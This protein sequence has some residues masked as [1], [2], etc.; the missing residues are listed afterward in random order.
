MELLREGD[1]RIYVTVAISIA[2]GMAI[3]GFAVQGLRAQGAPPVYFISDI[4][5]ITDPEAFK[6]VGQR[7]QSE[8]A[9][10]VAKA[11]GQY[12]TRTQKLTALYGTPPQR[13]IIIKFDN[14][15][16]AK[17]FANDE[18][19]KWIDSITDKATKIRRFYAEG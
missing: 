6:V 1:M 15:E 4:A 13:L 8:A 10:R 19:Q 11:G 2:A 16:K 7:P 9:A 12:V 18:T 3:G 5:E 17:A 14:M